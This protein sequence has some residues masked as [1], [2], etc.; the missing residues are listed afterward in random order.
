MEKII[1]A[2]AHKKYPNVLGIQ[3][4]PEGTYLHDLEIKYRKA[5]NDELKSGKQILI[6]HNSY[7]FHLEFWNTFSKKINSK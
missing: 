4:H 7:Q 6:D 2:I 1:E 5:P 3:F